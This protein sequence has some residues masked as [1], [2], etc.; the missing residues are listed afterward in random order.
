[1]HTH[2][3]TYYIRECARAGIARASRSKNTLVCT[4]EDATA[5]SD[6]GYIISIFLGECHMMVKTLPPTILFLRICSV[7]ERL[8]HTH[9]RAQIERQYNIH[10]AQWKCGALWLRALYTII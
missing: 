10:N 6:A 9:T 1:M 8:T 3:Y 2:K 5:P 7:D 4:H